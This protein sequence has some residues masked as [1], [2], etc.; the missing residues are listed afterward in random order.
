MVGKGPTNPVLLKAIEGMVSNSVEKQA[1]IW[2][3]IARDL[4]KPARQRAEV[5][6]SRLER[7]CKDGETIA[8]PG[9]VLASGT[10]SKKLTVAAWTFSGIAADKIKKAGG[11]ALEL[12]ELMKSNPGGKGVRL[13]K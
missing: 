9:K 8:V 5:N 7:Y 13:M 12:E 2:K 4:G 11:K 1:P 6:I 3:T 10:L